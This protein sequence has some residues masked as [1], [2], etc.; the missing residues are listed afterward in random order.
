MEN[1]LLKQLSKY[2]SKE[3][4]E[5]V[6]DFNKLIKSA[7]KYHNKNIKKIE[8]Y[9]W[10][11]INESL[12]KITNTICSNNYKVSD[13]KIEMIFRSNDIDFLIKGILY[14]PKINSLTNE[15]EYEPIKQSWYLD[16]GINTINQYKHGDTRDLPNIIKYK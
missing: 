16:G 6:K 14:Y 10:E 9:D 5:Y 15:V 12:S 2:V 3:I 8:L 13:L 4:R 7:N 11:S 1:K